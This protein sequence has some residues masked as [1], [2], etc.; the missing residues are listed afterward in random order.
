M[1]KLVFLAVAA[2]L[3]IATPSLA[4]LNAVPAVI[5]P[6]NQWVDV[7]ALAPAVTDADMRARMNAEIVRAIT[8][9]NG[10]DAA[11]RQAIAV[12]SERYQGRASTQS[13]RM[14]PSPK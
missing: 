6:A 11:A 10:D 1:R 9:A 8:E 3:S 7:P 2:V 13:A 12:I 5:P 14:A 4:Q